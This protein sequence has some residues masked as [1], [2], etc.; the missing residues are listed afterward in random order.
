MRPDTAS[1]GQMQ[2]GTAKYGHVRPGQVQQGTARYGQI[3]PDT[4]RYSQIRP[5]TTRD[6]QIQPDKES[7]REQLDNQLHGNFAKTHNSDAAKE[8]PTFEESLHFPFICCPG[9]KA[10]ASAA[11][12]S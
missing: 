11:D 9:L 1:Y 10:T 6:S 3:R 5:D 4:P 12:P 2:P 8:G 7:M